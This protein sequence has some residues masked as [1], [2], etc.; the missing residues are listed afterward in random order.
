MPF[1][2][3]WVLEDGK[4]LPSGV[5]FLLPGVHKV[6]AIK[7]AHTVVSGVFSEEIVSKNG[8]TVEAYAVVYFKVA[9]F[10]KS[11][12]Y[13]D[14]ETNKA[15]SEKAVSKLVQRFLAREVP[16]VEVNGEGVIADGEAL[17][18]KLLGYLKGK[19]S[20]FGLV[21]ESAEVRG[22]FPVSMQVPLKIRALEAP[23]PA[24]GTAGHNLSNDY[25]ADALTPPFFEKNVFGSR[26]EDKT[27]AAVSLVWAI[28]SPPDFH[29]FNH[30][31][32]VCINASEVTSVEKTA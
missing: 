14:P 20:E 18:E 28:P 4:V 26:K 31:P 19:E 17:G 21:F 8:Q 16:T 12:F 27:P 9:D 7:S 6:K 5:H 3:T 15:D 10:K 22:A 29:H 25:W 23:L 13:V 32:R 30:L 1:G 24:P 2:Q 11:A